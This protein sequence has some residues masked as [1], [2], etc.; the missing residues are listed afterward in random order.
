MQA[1]EEVLGLA[2]TRLDALM[3]SQ[4][5]LILYTSTRRASLW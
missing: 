3:G 1:R 2:T 5:G 4:Y